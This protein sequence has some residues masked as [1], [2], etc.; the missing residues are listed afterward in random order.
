MAMPKVPDVDF[1]TVAAKRPDA[2]AAAR[3]GLPVWSFYDRPEPYLLHAVAAGDGL[4]KRPDVP[5]RSPKGS[6]F[7]VMAARCA[8]HIRFAD[9]SNPY[10]YQGTP[11]MCVRE[12]RKWNKR[13]SFRCEKP[14]A[15]EPGGILYLEATERR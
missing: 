7:G 4:P 9:G 13:F 10:F 15:P 11:A 12:L 3:W 6:V 1:V 8:V 14:M 2:L 5:A